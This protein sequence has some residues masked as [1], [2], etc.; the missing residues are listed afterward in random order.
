M[1]D[2]VLPAK[3]R[4]P[5]YQ[6]AEEGKCVGM[7]GDPVYKVALAHHWARGDSS[8]SLLSHEKMNE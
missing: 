5:H 7:C 2:A 3:D 6:Q 1:S 8:V 4:S